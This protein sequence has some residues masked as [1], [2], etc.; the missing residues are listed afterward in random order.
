MN[1]RLKRL[2]VEIERH[3]NEIAVLFKPEMRLTFIARLPGNDEADVILTVD[4]LNEV[5]KVIERR[6]AS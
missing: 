1:D 4:D 6:N 5:A 3:L 2:H